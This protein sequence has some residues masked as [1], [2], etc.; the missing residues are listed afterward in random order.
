MGPLLVDPFHRDVGGRAASLAFSSFQ[1]PDNMNADRAIAVDDLPHVL[2]AAYTYELPIGSG[3]ALLNH[4]GFIDKVLGGWHLS[5][6]FNAQ[7][8]LPLSVTG[9][10]NELTNRLN[11]VGSPNFS[12]GRTKAERIHQWINPAGFEPVFGS[13][14]AFWAN[15]DSDDNRAWR[16]GTAGP[17]LA[18]LR[19]PG[20]WNMDA[21]L[22]KQFH[23]TEAK[24]FQFRW[25]VFNALN[26]QNLGTPNTSYCLSPTSDGSPDLVHQSGCQFGRIANIQTDPRAMQFALKF[27]F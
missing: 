5:G 21:G 22:S 27:F 16:F 2:N 23:I 25:E 26:H 20:F 17:R 14:Q 15:Y 4:K 19:G 6:N 11:L 10:S 24:Y 12:G 9:P 7:S 3:K 18:S 8:G 1:D 13:D